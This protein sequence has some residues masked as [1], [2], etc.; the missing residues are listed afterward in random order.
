MSRSNYLGVC[1]L[2]QN[3][4]CNVLQQYFRLFFILSQENWCL[5]KKRNMQHYKTCCNVTTY[6]KWILQY[7]QNFVYLSL[8]CNPF[9]S[10]WVISY[11]PLAICCRH[12]SK[13]L[14]KWWYTTSLC[15]FCI[16]TQYNNEN[17]Y[18]T[19]GK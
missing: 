1:I 10:I 3:K 13:L 14:G 2:R 18:R 17:G 5:N 19:A 9:T 16:F 6:S 12:N 11:N 8:L 15:L 4:A 7:L